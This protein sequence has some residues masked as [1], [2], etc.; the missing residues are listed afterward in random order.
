MVGE[1]RMEKQER[2]LAH[3]TL[4]KKLRGQVLSL[5]SPKITVYLWKVYRGEPERENS[6]V[7]MGCLDHQK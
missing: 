5:E 3:E 2:A 4:G 1:K 7:M 6:K